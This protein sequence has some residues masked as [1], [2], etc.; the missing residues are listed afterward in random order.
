MRSSRSFV[1]AATILGFVVGAL[2]PATAAAQAQPSGWDGGKWHYTASMYGW[3][4]EIKGT[5][6]LPGD[7][8]STDLDVSMSDVLK[9]LKMTF[10]GSFDAHNGRWGAF[11]DFIYVDI[12]GAKSNTKNF[13]VGGVGIP[14]SAT[15]DL[16]LDFKAIVWTVAGEYR[17]ASDPSWTVDL[18]GGARMLK[19]RPTLLY[20]ITGDI[21][22]VPIPGG[23]Y[24]SKEVN[25]TLWDGIVGVKGRYAFGDQK[26]WFAPFYA[27]VGTGQTKLTWQIAGGVGYRY[28]WGSVVA[29][30]RYLDYEAKSG[31]PVA[32]LSM[33]GPQIG[34]VFQW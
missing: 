10:M 30:Y 16:S 13:S 3:V 7:L 33:G 31:K 34:V 9:H 23:R 24:G 12:G 26:R 2:L 6:N 4:P 29:L 5:I 21:G 1:F 8:G 22:P 27:D 11:T 17:V 25:E 18:L 15:T 20:T 32:D 28:N 14:A 19:A